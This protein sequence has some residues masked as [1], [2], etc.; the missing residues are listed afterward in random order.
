MAAEQNDLFQVTPEIAGLGITEFKIKGGEVRAVMLG[1]TNTNDI[2]LLDNPC[3]QQA[4]AYWLMELHGGDVDAALESVTN[5]NVNFAL[6]NGVANT[7]TQSQGS[8]V[9]FLQA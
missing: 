9:T 6:R 5:A 3:W 4:V 8:N 1:A 2:A 7:G